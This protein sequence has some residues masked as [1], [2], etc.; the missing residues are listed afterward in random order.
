MS[1]K[2]EHAAK[3]REGSPAE[4]EK[5]I[6]E[7]QSKGSVLTAMASRVNVEIQVPDRLSV[8][9]TG[10]LDAKHGGTGDEC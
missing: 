10:C 9:F 8:G 2:H 7:G 1:I 3:D 6:L 4:R 5:S